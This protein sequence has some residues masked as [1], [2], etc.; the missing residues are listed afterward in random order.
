[1]EIKQYQAALE[2]ILFA[3]GE[4]VAIDRLAA[5][6]ELDNDAVETLAEDLAQD[7]RT[8]N[9]GL[10]ILRLDD[11]YQMCTKRDFATYIRSAMEIRRNTPLSQAAME[12]LAIVAYNQPVT[13]AVIEQ[14]RG[15]DCSAVLQGLQLKG[16]VEEKGRLELPGRPL[17]Y[18]TTVHFLRCF[19]VSSLAELPPL[20]QKGGDEVMEEPTLDEM[21]RENEALGQ[22]EAVLE[23]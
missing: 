21:I 2:A 1:M 19:G 3:S 22:V 17:L 5:A 6:L 12:V 4:P 14:V 11:S 16:L 8:K 9:G 15:V 18:G 23:P 10:T 13:K 7:Y 20:P